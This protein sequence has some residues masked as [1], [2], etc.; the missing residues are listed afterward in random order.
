MPAVSLDEY[1]KNFRYIPPTDPD[2]VTMRGETPVAASQASSVGEE[3]SSASRSEEAV[4]KVIVDE[5]AP[6]ETSGAET[7]P[8]ESEPAEVVASSVA[9][10]QADP[11]RAVAAMQP[12]VAADAIV[13]PEVF[14]AKDI[15]I[16]S[17]TSTTEAAPPTAPVKEIPIVAA[18]A[19]PIVADD[20]RERLGLDASGPA[21]EPERSRFLDLAKPAAKERSGTS[22]LVGP[23]FLGLDDSL[24]A[25]DSAA[26]GDDVPEESSTHWRYWMVA[27]IVLLAVIL[28]GLQWRAQV[29]QTTGPLEVVRLKL[30][31]MRG[32]TAPAQN[33][34]ATTAASNGASQPGITVEQPRTSRPTMRR[35]WIERNSSGCASGNRFLHGD[36][37]SCATTGQLQPDKFNSGKFQQRG[38]SGEF[39]RRDNCFRQA[40]DVRRQNVNE[41]PS[42]KAASDH[43]Q[44]RFRQ[45]HSNRADLAAEE[46]RANRQR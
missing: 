4:A 23:S 3:M 19:A 12:S 27:A 45:E 11:E 15:A 9:S 16:A 35:E 37:Q 20:V 5:A 42:L 39:Q 34:A 43:H 46:A 28:G 14:P 44:Q 32:E 10:Q 22:S 38:R 36:Q 6:A 30:R 33:T 7:T 1:V 2:E 31:Q 26:L 8:E 25:T 21:E 29:N 40:A 18:T 24:P 17:E 13:A 41:Y